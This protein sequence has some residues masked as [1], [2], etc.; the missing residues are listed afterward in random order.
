MFIKQNTRFQISKIE[1]KLVAFE[2]IEEKTGNSELPFFVSLFQ[3]YPKGDKL[4]NII[5]VVH[6]G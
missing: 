5:G 3:G 4:E 1:N 2:V 6:N